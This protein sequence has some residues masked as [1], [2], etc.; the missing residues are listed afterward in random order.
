M[1]T[2]KTVIAI[3]TLSLLMQACGDRPEPTISVIKLMKPI[4]TIYLPIKTKTPEPTA[5][6][7]PKTSQVG[8]KN[9]SAHQRRRPTCEVCRETRKF[10][11]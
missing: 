3:A 11:F 9:L 2:F 10:C 6:A 4:R 1:K 5:T 8:H 7:E